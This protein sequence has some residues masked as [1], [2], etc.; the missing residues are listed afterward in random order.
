MR[1]DVSGYCTA[2]LLLGVLVIA[3]VSVAL[4]NGMGVTDQR[5]WLVVLVCSAVSSVAGFAFSALAGSLLLQFSDDALYV[6]QVMLV[7]SITMQ[8]YSV[9]RLRADIHL[10]PLLPFFAGGAATVVPGVLL[11]LKV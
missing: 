7:A 10:K 1:K 8:A 6:V 3:L 2:S 9:W 5:M 11:L 4:P